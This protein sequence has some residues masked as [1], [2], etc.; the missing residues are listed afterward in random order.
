MSIKLLSIFESRKKL[1]VVKNN[2]AVVKNNQKEK[3][4]HLGRNVSKLRE[5]K[6]IKQEEFAKLLK[7][8][9]QAVSKLENRQEIDDETI[10]KIAEKLGF[11]PDSIKEFNPDATV[12]S[13]NQQGG[14]VI[15]I[16][17]LDKIIELYERMLK[18]KDMQLN[19]KDKEIELLKR[20]V[21]K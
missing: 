9:Q 2:S 11:T 21:K 10:E 19:V 13:I 17:P 14:N 18:E 3:A 1:L 8:T 4:M 16:N 20:G 12:Q 6:G 7:I 15:N 5:L